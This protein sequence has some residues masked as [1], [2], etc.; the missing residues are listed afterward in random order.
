MATVWRI[1]LRVASTIGLMFLVLLVGSCVHEVG[2]HLIKPHGVPYCFAYPPVVAQKRVL[3]EGNRLMKAG[4][5]EAAIGFFRAAADDLL[6][7]P[8]K[9]RPDRTDR[10]ISEGDQYKPTHDA[11][12]RPEK[13]AEA[14]DGMRAHY[15]RMMW[16][17]RYLTCQTLF[18]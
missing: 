9:A 14:A 5:Y 15:E 2:P 6:H 1:A 12:A 8:L 11:L 3:A 18:G 4:R 17:Y 10:T 7:A 16:D 13:A